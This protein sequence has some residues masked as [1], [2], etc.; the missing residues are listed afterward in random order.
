MGAE[1]GDSFDS[2]LMKTTRPNHSCERTPIK[3]VVRGPEPLRRRSI[4]R[5][6]GIA[7]FG[8]TRV[9]REVREAHAPETTVAVWMKSKRTD[10]TDLPMVPARIRGPG[11]R[12]AGRSKVGV[13]GESGFDD[14]PNHSCERTPMK[15]VVQSPEPLRRRSIHR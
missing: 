15:P 4:Q 7:G 1:G 9:V 12:V 2:V 13:R 10:C 6:A 11:R 5:S 3:P 8:P 14:L